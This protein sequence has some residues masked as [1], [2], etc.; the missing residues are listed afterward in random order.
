MRK[1]LMILLGLSALLILGGVSLLFGQPSSVLT[2]PTVQSEASIAYNS[3]LVVAIDDAGSRSDLLAVGGAVLL[4]GGL[5]VS[6]AAYGA[7]LA[8]RGLP[9]AE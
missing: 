4:L 9:D 1:R 7:Q 3:E 5:M 2:L 8:Q 6:A